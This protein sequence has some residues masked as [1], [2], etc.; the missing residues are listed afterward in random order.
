MYDLRSKLTRAAI[1]F[2]SILAFSVVFILFLCGGS[3]ITS[4]LPI[5]L[6]AAAFVICFGLSFVPFIRDHLWILLPFA[7]L[8][9]LAV[10]FILRQFV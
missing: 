2:V 9:S 3:I 8:F 7:I 10:S 5:I 4:L 1:F 6:A